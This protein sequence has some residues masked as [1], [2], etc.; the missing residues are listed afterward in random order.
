MVKLKQLCEKLTEEYKTSE[1]TI[2]KQKKDIEATQEELAKANKELSQFHS[3]YADKEAHT[4]KV[5]AELQSMQQQWQA[6]KD[7][8]IEAEIKLQ[9]LTQIYQKDSEEK[10]T[11]L[12][13]LYQRLVAGCV[14]IKQ[15]EGLLGRF[16]WSELCAVL[17]E[18]ADALTSDL[19]SANEKIAHLECV[20]E[21]L[22][23]LQ[24]RQEDT[25]D[26]LTQQMK[27][28]EDS[29]LK[30]K[31]EMELRYSSMIG[32]L[33]TKAQKYQEVANVSKERV[34]HLE[35]TRDQM[36]FDLAHFH[37]T[38]PQLQKEKA[39]L[40]SGCALLAGALYPLYT[41]LCVLS[42]QKDLLQQQ[43]STGEKAISHMQTLIHALTTEED[44]EKEQG[45][46]QKTKLA[47]GLIKIFRKGVIV[48]LAAHR[49]LALGQSSSC[50][51]TWAENFQELPEMMVCV[52]GK[53]LE[54][55]LTNT[56]SSSS[57][58]LLISATRRSFFKLM[59]RL[60]LEM[61][62]CNSEPRRPGCAQKGTLIRRLAEGLQ[63]VNSKMLK[64]GIPVTAKQTAV[65][66]QQH[67]LEFT[68]RLHAAEVERRNLRLELKRN[69]ERMK[70]EEDKAL[71]IKASAIPRDKFENICTELDN[72][73]QREQQA[74]QLL[75]EQAEQLDEL[76]QRLEQHTGE[77]AEKDHTLS[78]AVKANK[79]L[80][81]CKWRDELAVK[82][83]NF[84]N[85]DQIIRTRVEAMQW[86]STRDGSAFREGEVLSLI[87]QQSLSEAKMEL[88]RK[89]QSVRQLR[90]QLSQRDQDI[91]RLEENIHD[92]ESALCTA[93]KCKEILATYLKSINAN[94]KEVK[95]QISLS[96]SAATRHDFTL[97]LPKLH[98]EIFGADG[99][100]GGAEVAACQ[101]HNAVPSHLTLH[102]DKLPPEQD[103][104]ALNAEP[105][106]TFALLRETSGNNRARFSKS[107]FSSSLSASRG[108]KR[109]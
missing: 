99:L 107:S 64:E 90:K 52:G 105:D 26:S 106:Y 89:D 49:F 82:I 88:R 108:T 34:L 95:D 51:F 68:R 56:S 46:H 100:K 37:Q 3:Q 66:L 98:L 53:K 7:R 48:I 62:N 76:G 40:L 101:V 61:H 43:V 57:S 92:A 19:T 32:E 65:C 13:G 44:K 14:L 50:L 86:F 93:A 83:W 17:Q 102:S 67:I 25:V 36:T 87:P 55:Q 6:E 58:Q 69:L 27:A 94:L 85:L 39:A 72:A 23:D 22:K 20:C 59:D 77:E 47:T 74:Q 75:R 81:D 60:S 63:E 35:K 96:W 2:W 104:A 31:K 103:F 11:F 4:K 28:Q 38:M 54:P 15:P 10:L 84:I 78:E 79:L 73:L 30:Q 70:M 33:H 97:Q 80:I 24:K 21:T 8:V 109:L 71:S 16:S 29:W 45:E 18:Q 5:E 1:E 9:R 42:S 41:Q 91:R 12:H